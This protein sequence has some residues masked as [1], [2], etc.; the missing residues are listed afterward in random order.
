MKLRKKSDEIMNIVEKAYGQCLAYDDCMCRQKDQICDSFT[1][2]N[3]SFGV[4]L[5]SHKI[6]T[7]LQF[8]Y[9]QIKISWENDNI[10]FRFYETKLIS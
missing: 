8:M 10:V 1:H 3:L 4:H 7:N 6:R 9:R 5:G 2:A